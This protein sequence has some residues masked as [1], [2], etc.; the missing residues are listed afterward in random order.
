MLFVLLSWVLCF[1]ICVFLCM[2][3]NRVGVSKVMLGVNQSCLWGFS[4]VLGV[5][6][7]MYPIPVDWALSRK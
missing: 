6:A 3:M 5:L 4:L 1:G 2:P 7:S